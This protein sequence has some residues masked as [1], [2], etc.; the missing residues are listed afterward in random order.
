MEQKITQVWGGLSEAKHTI[1]VL[2][3]TYISVSVVNNCT[4][5]HPH[6]VGV[7]MF[8]FD[9]LNSQPCLWRLTATSGLW[10]KLFFPFLF[11][12]KKHIE[13]S[14][15][16]GGECQRE[17]AR[18]PTK[19]KMKRFEISEDIHLHPAECTELYFSAIVGT[20]TKVTDKEIQCL[21]ATW[22]TVML[23]AVWL[24]S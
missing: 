13:S 12:S 4:Y 22:V 2:S 6:T 5:E 7:R 24:L 3:V 11:H 23:T 19:K 20:V 9:P 15:F 17:L 18:R 21:Y 16:I 14:V 8:L 1:H 10:Q